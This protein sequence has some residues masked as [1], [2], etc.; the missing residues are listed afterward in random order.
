MEKINIINENSN[1]WQ[2]VWGESAEELLGR[3]DIDQSEK[4]NLK[5]ETI[6]ILSKCNNPNK[7][8]DSKTGLVFGHIQSGKTMSFTALIALAIDNGYKIVVVI[9]GT[10][11]ELSTQT[12]NRLKNDL[13][14]DNSTKLKIEQNL[15]NSDVIKNTIDS[16]VNTDTPDRYKKVLL[17][18]VLKNQSPLK[19]I[20]TIFKE[21]NTHNLP[22][23][24]IDDEA[25]QASLN[26]FAR[27]NAKKT[28]DEQKKSTIYNCITELK[29]AIP[30]HTL[31]QY[32]ATPQA[33]I[34]IN[35]IDRLSPS[36]VELVSPGMDYIGG[37]EFFKDYKDKLI[38]DIPDEDIEAEKMP[39]SLKDAMMFFFVGSSHLAS[40]GTRK[41]FS[42]MVHPHRYTEPHKQYRDWIKSQKSYWVDILGRNDSDNAKIKLVKA[43][44]KISKNLNISAT[45]FKEIL[46]EI[47]FLIKHTNIIELNSTSTGTKPNWNRSDSHILVG[48]TMLDRGFTVKNLIVSYMPRDKGVGNADTIQQRAR[49]FGYKKDYMDFCRVYLESEVSDLF[50]KY[51]EHEESL[52]DGFRAWQES[53]DPINQLNRYFILDK[54]LKPT[55]GNVLSNS[56]LRSDIGNDKW[57][58]FRVPHDSKE[59]V[60][61][62]LSAYDDFCAKYKDKFQEDI[63]DID[64]TEEQKH[65]V[66][67][68]KAI[69]L[70]NN[71]LEKLKFTRESESARY[72]NIKSVIGNADDDENITVYIMSKGKI[73]TRG[74][75]QEKDNIE[76]LFQGKN[77]KSGKIIY[78][79]DDKI[80]SNGITI[81]IH[82]LNIRNT[83][84]YDVVSLSV[85]M[86]KK[87]K[88]DIISQ[89]V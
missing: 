20:L 17:T 45:G 26:T 15:S 5:K 11:T 82:K 49:F 56:P 35:T 44:R 21:I 79:G 70:F 50:T 54:K 52:K 61:N 39:K 63:G 12:Y 36:F 47:P 78:P 48:G 85:W 62:N 65:F 41:M 69:D 29:D 83:D 76:N 66:I 84:F 81:Q 10:T 86:P 55:R 64:R 7:Q 38:I 16:W 87:F 4:D 74:L 28:D 58:Q 89:N 18:T 31:A 59:I 19:K 77:P 75:L 3:L 60:K 8:E 46:K 23:L 34:F 73:R 27:V 72:L 37:K 9:S 71:F 14:I 67:E 2:P 13:D 24:I 53:G 6:K 30:N 40:K 1:E 88:Q 68:I 57:I 32:T 42:M 51:V 25:D 80:K 33:P 22:V 43:F